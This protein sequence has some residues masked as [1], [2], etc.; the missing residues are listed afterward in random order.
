MTQTIGRF[1]RSNPEERRLGIVRLRLNH[2]SLSALRAL[3][4]GHETD[5]FRIDFRLYDS[6]SLP[7]NALFHLLVERYA[8]RSGQS[9]EEAK[10]EL[11]HLYGVVYSWGP[12][13]YP[14]A[15]EGRFAKIYDEIEF[16]VSTAEYTKEEMARLIEGAQVSCAEVGA[17]A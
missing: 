4:R 12:E 9:R 13:F 5:L 15:R 1:E 10:I 8:E 14:P 11:K 17:E 2:D 7:Q 3:A 6:R 16:Q